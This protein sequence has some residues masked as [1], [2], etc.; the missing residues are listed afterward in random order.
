M[1]T[2]ITFGCGIVTALR[3]RVET[4]LG[5]WEGKSASFICGASSE[6]HWNVGGE[7]SRSAGVVRYCA[8]GGSHSRT[9]RTHPRLRQPVASAQT[10]RSC[11]RRP[12][13]PHTLREPMVQPAIIKQLGIFRNPILL[14]EILLISPA[15]NT[16]LITRPGPSEVLKRTHSKLLIT[17]FLQAAVNED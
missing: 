10:L 3:S 17:S 5:A 14:L 11:R 2:I 4:M 6:R 13:S 8:R 16:H 15:L 9:H 7:L 1:E 12:P